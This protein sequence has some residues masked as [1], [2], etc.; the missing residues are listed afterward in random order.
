[1]N[2]KVKNALEKSAVLAIEI[3]VLIAFAGIFLTVGYYIGHDA[4]E[5]DGFIQAYN[6]IKDVCFNEL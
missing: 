1:M 5:G 3:A 6:Y 2:W 4:G